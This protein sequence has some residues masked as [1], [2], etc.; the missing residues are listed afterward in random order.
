MNS[1]SEFDLEAKQVVDARI[2]Q[3][4]RS[5]F[6]DVS[7]LPEATGEDQ[8]IAGRKCKLTVFRQRLM[9]DHL[10]VTVQLACPTLAGLATLHRERGLVFSAD[11]EVREATSKEL[12]ESGG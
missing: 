7:A 11:G 6:N 1:G 9:S 3:L 4:Q 5:R 8:L 2:A 12:T 10:L